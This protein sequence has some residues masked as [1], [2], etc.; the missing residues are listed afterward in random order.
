[1][2]HSVWWSACYT[3]SLWTYEPVY[4]FALPTLEAGLKYS[5]LGILSLMRPCLKEPLTPVMGVSS[6]N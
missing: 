1:M 3:G 6:I 4:M 2:C 5:V